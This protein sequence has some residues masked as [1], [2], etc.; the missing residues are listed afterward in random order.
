MVFQDIVG[1]V[2]QKWGNKMAYWKELLTLKD[3]WVGVCSNC[4][5]NIYGHFKGNDLLSSLP[6]KCPDCGEIIFK[7]KD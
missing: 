4:N 3:C 1:I 2:E 6:K 7:E 5:R